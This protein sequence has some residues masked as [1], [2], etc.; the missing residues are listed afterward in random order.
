MEKNKIF[1]NSII[2][3][4]WKY[5]EENLKHVNDV[6]D[7]YVGQ[8]REIREMVQFEHERAPGQSF[9]YIIGLFRMFNGWEYYGGHYPN[10]NIQQLL[11]E[12]IKVFIREMRQP[13]DIILYLPYA[14]DYGLTAEQMHA[15]HL[16]GELELITTDY[17][18]INVPQ[19]EDK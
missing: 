2:F 18:K 4:M 7:T 10:I 3:S 13:W 19:K 14:A 12:A 15:A 6:D 17:Y 8:H 1:S 9:N 5:V 11:A 16:N